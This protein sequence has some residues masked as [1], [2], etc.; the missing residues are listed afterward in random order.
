MVR[1]PEHGKPREQPLFL[2]VEQVIAP[3]DRR[4][5]GLVT[6]VPV[7]RAAAQGVKADGKL[8]K[9]LLRREQP[10]RAAASSI[11]SGS[12]SSRMQIAAIWRSGLLGQIK[13]SPGG[14]R[15]L[16][17]QPD[18]LDIGSPRRRIKRG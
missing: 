15:T 10:V 8:L 14:G 4:P 18:R 11:A 9:Q 3:V 7:T 12:P 5:Q 13:F 1:P 6:L 17:K 2:R 16:H